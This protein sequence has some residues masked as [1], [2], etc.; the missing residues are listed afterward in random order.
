MES[1]IDISEKQDKKRRKVRSAWI[2]FVGRIMAQLIG[3][4]AT[5]FLGLIVVDKYKAL[6]ERHHADGTAAGVVARERSGHPALAVLPVQDYSTDKGQ[7]G[8][9]DA[10]TEAMIAELAQKAP[11]R[12][13]S[14]TSSMAFRATTRSLPAIAR[15]LGADWIVESSIVRDG[16]RVR[17]TSQLIDART[18]EHL[19]ARVYEHDA[20]D[21]LDAQTRLAMDVT[22]DLNAVLRRNTKD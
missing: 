14:R 11:V 8:V 3:A 12:V 19:L 2:S 21:L 6:D 1:D 15:E 18:D 13:L 16:R 4:A 10:I 20:T 7:S 22:A 17:L 5:I 9:A